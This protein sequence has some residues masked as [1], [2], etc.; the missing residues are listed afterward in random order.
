V[1]TAAGESPFLNDPAAPETS[2]LSL[3]DALP[4]YGHLL[5]SKTTTSQPANGTGYALGE[6]ISYQIKVTNDGNLTITNIEV[7]DSLSDAEGQVIG[8]IE[9]LAPGESKDFAFE[10]VVTEADILNGSVKNV[11]TAAGESPDP[12]EPEVPVTPGEKEDV[13]EEKNGHLLVSKTTT[14]Q[15]A[16]GTAYV[17]GEKILYAITVSNDGNLTLTEIVV[18][19]ELTGDEWKI[20]SLA[21]GETKVFEVEYTVTD[22]DFIKGSVINEVTVSGTDPEGKDVDGGDTVEVPVTEEEPKETE[23]ETET[24]AKVKETEQTKETPKTGDTTNW[25]GW[26]LLL[27]VSG[28]ILTGGIVRKSHKRK[29][30]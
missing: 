13:T 3:H 6:T 14:S 11:A 29:T 2:T 25:F 27:A 5:V 12:D 20:A 19:D 17:P 26:I 9:S 21:P 30:K 7:T 18:T 28:G 23:S 1:A 22:E 8:T 24:E 16:N 4:I 15:P 10:Y